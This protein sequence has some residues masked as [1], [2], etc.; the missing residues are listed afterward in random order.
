MGFTATLT[1][2][3]KMLKSFCKQIYNKKQKFSPVPTS[4][5][6]QIRYNKTL[7]AIFPSAMSGFFTYH[8]FQG[9]TQGGGSGGSGEPPFFQ[10][11]YIHSMAWQACLAC[12]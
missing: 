8:N 9:R 7:V 11:N 3:K 2:V 4:L 1:P 10:I 12:K 5:A 6:Y